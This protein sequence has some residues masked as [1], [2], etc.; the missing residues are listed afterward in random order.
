[1]S[2]PPIVVESLAN[3]NQVA[4]QS[5]RH[6]SRHCGVPQRS[7]LRVSRRLLIQELGPWPDG[8]GLRGPPG[9]SYGHDSSETETRVSD[10]QDRV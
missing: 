2:C 5:P 8:G 1:M 7:L 6:L 9:P 4:G 10:I 3:P